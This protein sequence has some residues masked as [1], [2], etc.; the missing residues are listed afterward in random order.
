MTLVTL[1]DKKIRKRHSEEAVLL[2]CKA[3]VT[4]HPLSSPGEDPTRGKLL[5]YFTCEV[6]IPA[7]AFDFSLHYIYRFPFLNLNSH[8]FHLLLLFIIIVIRNNATD[9]A[10]IPIYLSKFNF[11]N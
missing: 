7:A 9:N 6:P 8:P 3:G 1:R 10:N 5:Y 11:Y 4:C 2:V